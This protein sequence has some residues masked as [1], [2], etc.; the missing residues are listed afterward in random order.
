VYRMCV[1]FARPALGGDISPPF[2]RQ[3]D[4]KPLPSMKS[5]LGIP[6]YVIKKK[7]SGVAHLYL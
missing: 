3:L 2:L 4:V 6:A 5:R 7:C 1:S